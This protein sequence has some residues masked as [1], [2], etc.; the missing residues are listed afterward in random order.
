MNV[1][2]LSELLSPEARTSLMRQDYSIK[3]S[4]E[5]I[6]EREKRD[7]VGSVLTAQHDRQPCIMRFRRDL[8]RPL[9]E[10]ASRALQELDMFLQITGAHT[11]SMLHLSSLDL[12]AGS[13]ILLDNRRWLYARSIIKDPERHLRRVRWDPVPFQ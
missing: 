4:L 6:K 8:I 1:Q 9:T 7:I 3:I 11:Q 13:I 2:K 12:P 5:F 10:R